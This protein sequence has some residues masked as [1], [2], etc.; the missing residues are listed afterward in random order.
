M[1]RHFQPGVLLRRLSLSLCTI[2]VGSCGGGDVPSVTTPAI[3]AAVSEAPAVNL[4]KAGTSTQILVLS[5]RADLISGGDALVQVAVS[6]GN[7]GA[8]TKIDVDGRDVTSAFALRADGRYMGLV[9]GLVNGPNELRARLSDGS[10]ARITIVNHPIG[11]SVFSGPQVQP[12]SCNPGASG[13]QCSRD[14]VFQYFYVPAGIDPQAN[15]AP[16]DAPGGSDSYF[17]AYDPAHP[18]PPELVAKTTT[19]QGVTVPF[20]VRLETG[21]INRAQYQIAVLYDPSGHWNFAA[22]QLA[23]NHKLFLIGGH[24]CGISYQEGAAPGVL[25]GKVLGKGFATASSSLEVTGNN[26]NLVTQAETLMM[27]KEHFIETYGLVRYTMS[28]GGSGASIVQQWT[29]NA[30]PGIYDGLIV[31]ASFPDAWTELMNTEDCISLVDY[32][33]TPTRW[34]PAVVWGPVEQSSVESGDAASSCAAFVVD[35]KSVFT[36]AD[37]TGQVP[38]GTAY[39]AATNPAGVRGT[40]WDYSVSQLGRRTSTQWGPIEQHLGYG[41]ANRPLDTVGIQYGLKALLNGQITPQQFVDMNV[42]VGGHDIDYNGQPGRTTADLAALAT[43]YRGGYI[44]QANNLH[45]PIIDIRGTSNS[46]LHDTFHSWSMR[47]RLE[48]ANGNHDNQIIWDSMTASGFVVDPALEAQAFGLMDR[49]L[50]AIEADHST[51]TPAQKV[52]ANKPY[53]AV[54]RCTVPG[55]GVPSP[56]VI[57]SSGNPRMGAGEPLTDDI[58]KCQLKPMNRTEYFPAIFTDDEWAR[59][60]TAFPSGVCDYTKPGVNQQP[61]IAWLTYANGPGGQPLGP[62]PTS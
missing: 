53:D 13:A 14:P 60:Q 52:V 8:V 10:G 28:I 33:T 17:Q 24:S 41:F 21:S 49:W 35:F 34:G 58:L 47:A 12:W 5:N 18:P 50:A 9:T 2:L 57:P 59:L 22:P 26:C 54:D 45:V 56:C 3:N 6:S 61:T 31:E 32:W 30:F 7:Y 15:P 38:S 46:E 29:A 55:T 25:I 1:T 43:V 16:V 51:R 11:G 44:N 37:E 62:P 39:D 36:P 19:D 23:W 48:R 42:K 27:V 20:I 40:I 4:A